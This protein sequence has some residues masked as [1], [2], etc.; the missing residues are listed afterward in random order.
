[1]ATYNKFNAF[2]EHVFEKVH[3]F[4]NDTF[5]VILTNVAPVA[6]NSVK[7]DITEIS[8]G[9]G[10]TAGGTQATIASSSQTSGVYKSVLNDVV[11]TATG[12]SM[13]TFRY[14]VLLNDSPS[15]PLDPLIAWWD[16]GSAITLLVGETFTWDVN[17]SNGIFTVT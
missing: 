12:G 1:M 16:Y 9:N 7:A 5:K 3:D 8:A 13:A 2:L 6:G 10:Y 17:A 11:F 15:S 14:A 4:Q